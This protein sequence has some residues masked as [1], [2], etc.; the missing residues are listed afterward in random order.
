MYAMSTE[1]YGCWMYALMSHTKA[2][3]LNHHVK[4]VLSWK[5]S[6]AYIMAQAR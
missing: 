4:K 5:G 1:G 2:L 6:H 3:L